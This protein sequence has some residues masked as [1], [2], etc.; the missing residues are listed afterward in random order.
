MNI[1][2][3]HKFRLLGV[4]CVLALSAC[5]EPATESAAPAPGAREA[6]I[7]A[8]CHGGLGI[9]PRKHAPDLSQRTKEYLVDAMLAYG[10]GRRTN[11]EMGSFVNGLTD[12]QRQLIAEFYG[13]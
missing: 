11:L 7:C 5:S 10:D 8:S 2:P 4:V 3:T 1:D 6:A 12:Q 9:R 13:K